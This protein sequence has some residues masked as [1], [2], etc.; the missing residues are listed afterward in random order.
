MQAT[1]FDFSIN[2][3]NVDIQFYISDS[4][5]LNIRNDGRVV[6]IRDIYKD[7]ALT[8]SIRINNDDVEDYQDIDDY[9]SSCR[10]RVYINGV[11]GYMNIFALDISQGFNY[12]PEYLLRDSNYIDVLSGRM[13]YNGAFLQNQ[14]MYIIRGSKYYRM[15]KMPRSMV[16][17]SL[18][19]FNDD[20]HIL[21]ETDNIKISITEQPGFSISLD[22]AKNISAPSRAYKIIE[23]TIK[24]E[25]RLYFEKTSLSGVLSIGNS[26]MFTSFDSSYSDVL[27]DKFAELDILPPDLPSNYAD[28]IYKYGIMS[29]N[30]FI[31][32][33]S[34]LSKHSRFTID[35]GDF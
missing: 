22:S 12:I 8:S 23:N 15:I 14:T 10:D 11:Y 30:N 33:E 3:K 7:Y 18:S 19:P 2:L 20:V 4:N 32:I 16:T 13:F 26:F 29:I 34:L 1:V 6:E 27:Y 5:F 25:Y 24:R 28:G 35:E 31:Q 9:C 21:T 17:A